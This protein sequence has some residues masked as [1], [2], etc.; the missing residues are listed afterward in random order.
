MIDC[1]LTFAFSVW[2]KCL[3][4]REPGP[5]CPMLI[6]NSHLGDENPAMNALALIA[7]AAT[8]A[9][10]DTGSASVSSTSTVSTNTVRWGRVLDLY[11][12]KGGLVVNFGPALLVALVCFVIVAIAWK[13]WLRQKLLP[14]FE[15]VEAEL[16]IANLGKIKIKPNHDNV[17]IAH[18]A[19]V[20]L[21]TRKAA[22]PFEDDHD[23]VAEIYD[24]YLQL[25]VRLRDL[26]KNIPAHKL[27]KCRDTRKLVEVMVTVLNQGLRPHLTRWQ[28]RFRRWYQD[29]LNESSNRNKSPQ[30][31][32]KEFP[33]FGLLV[34]DLK[35]LQ[36]DV[37]KYGEFLREIAQ[38]KDK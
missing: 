11:F 17:Q 19:W 30:E 29:A 5:G 26:T 24:S 3:L 2:A 20:E 34:K 28:A 9:G 18:E 37:V 13:F 32:Q 27:R 8:V 38:G 10:A 23:V 15:I 4:S 12:E 35:A 1:M 6:D 7:E 22:L 36:T 14:E 25:F 33:N 16:E 31:I 21:T